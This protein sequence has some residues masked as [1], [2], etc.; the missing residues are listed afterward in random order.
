MNVKLTDQL[1]YCL[2]AQYT[3]FLA[4]SQ[5]ARR[6]KENICMELGWS[7]QTFQRYLKYSR[8]ATKAEEEVIFKVGYSLLLEMQLFT[9]QIIKERK[10]E[11]TAFNTLI[12][13]Y[14]KLNH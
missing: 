2:S 8:P 12:I 5:L 11:N 9:E 7:D 13:G 1:G 14:D 3:F 6:F 4:H 10:S